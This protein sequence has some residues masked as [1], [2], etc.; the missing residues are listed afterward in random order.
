MADEQARRKR[1]AAERAVEQVRAGMVVGLGTGST[2]EF[3]IRA[4]GERVAAGLE[5]VGVPTSRRSEQLAR[6]L[7]IPLAELQDIERIDLTIDGADEVA[8]G[9]LDVLKGHG[10]AL[11]REKLVALATAHQVIVA[12]DSK[13]VDRLGTLC[14]VPVEVVPFGWRLPAA[15]LEALGAR[16]VLRSLPGSN[17]P[18]VTDNANYIVDAHFGPIP[19]PAALAAEIKAIAGVVDHGLFIGIVDQ[20]IIAGPEGVATFNHA[21]PPR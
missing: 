7:G 6:E 17:E 5:I 21:A 11:L 3:A 8:R 18:Y 10:G 13:L 15:A 12:D 2:A 1:A 19:D 20:V 16:V 4:L 9:T 14:A